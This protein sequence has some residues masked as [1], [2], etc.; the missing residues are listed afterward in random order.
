MKILEHTELRLAIKD[1]SSSYKIYPIHNLFP[2]KWHSAINVISGLA[3]LTLSVAWFIGK[4]PAELKLACQFILFLLAAPLVLDVAGE[5][6]SKA[7]YIFDKSLGQLTVTDKKIIKRYALSDVVDVVA[8]ST[9][10]YN[11]SPAYWKTIH[12]MLRSGEEFEL[13]PGHDKPEKQEE[14]TKLLRQFLNLS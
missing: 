1:G 6:G 10:G 13:H 7:I 5:E 8:T 4:I 11:S 14:L 3:I 9:E 12:L 2:E